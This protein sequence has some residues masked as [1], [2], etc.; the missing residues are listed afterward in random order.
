MIDTKIFYRKDFMSG[1]EQRRDMKRTNKV[2]RV[3]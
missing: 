1:R 2:V 3:F